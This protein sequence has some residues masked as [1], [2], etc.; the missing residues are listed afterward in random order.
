MKEKV[1][2]VLLFSS[3]GFNAYFIW[4]KTQGKVV[5]SNDLEVERAITPEQ[6]SHEVTKKIRLIQKTEKETV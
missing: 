1:L 5:S 3:L 4:N 2:I 6:K